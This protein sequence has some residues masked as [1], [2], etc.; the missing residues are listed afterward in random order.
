MVSALQTKS[1]IGPAGISNKFIYRPSGLL[2]DFDFLTAGVLATELLI[3]CH[4]YPII[5][6]SGT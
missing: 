6:A 5:F 3:I 4:K 1:I 2:K